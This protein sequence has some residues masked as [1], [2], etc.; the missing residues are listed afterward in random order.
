MTAHDGTYLRSDR[1][2]R[3]DQRNRFHLFRYPLREQSYEREREVYDHTREQRAV[4]TVEHAAVTGHYLAHIF[5]THFALNTAFHKIAEL[6]RRARDQSDR[7]I[8]GQPYMHIDKLAHDDRVIGKVD[9]RR[10]EHTP[11]QPA[12]RADDRLVGADGRRH[13][14]REELAQKPTE[15]V[16]EG[17]GTGRNDEYEQDQKIGVE[18]DPF[19]RFGIRFHRAGIGY[20]VGEYE[21]AEQQYGVHRRKERYAEIFGVRFLVA[22]DEQRYERHCQREKANA[23]HVQT[24]TEEIFRDR[25]SG[26]A[27]DGEDKHHRAFGFGRFLFHRAEHFERADERERVHERVEKEVVYEYFQKIERNQ[28]GYVRRTGDQSDLHKFNSP[29][30]VRPFFRICGYAPKTIRWLFPS[31][32]RKIRG[33]FFPKSTIRNTPPD[34]A[35]NSTAALPCPCG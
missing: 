7:E 28:H 9:D 3:T 19:Q 11:E 2:R 4:D 23:R 27:D 18:R 25:A 6:R 22:N 29:S 16:R 5:D 32:D 17:I 20:V 10:A 15:H 26:Y 21:N 35:G 34:R 13:L 8:Y 1:T 12:D 33:T 24:V 31:P 30:T 14:P